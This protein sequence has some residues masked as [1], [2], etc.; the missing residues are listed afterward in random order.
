MQETQNKIEACASLIQEHRQME[1]LLEKLKK[2]LNALNAKD[3]P[4]SILTVMREIEPEMNTHFACEEQVLFPA[5][6][7]YHPMVLMEVEHEELIA[8]RQELLT[9][10]TDGG[11]I[12]LNI[13]QL[14]EIGNR[15]I[16][17]MLDH[18]GR[19]DTGIFPAC[20]RALS[21]EE[22]EA[23]IVGMEKIRQQARQTPTPSIT[24]PDRTFKVHQLDVSSEPQR[25]I[26]SKRIF[27]DAS[28]EAKQITIQAGKSL[29]AHWTPK[30][31]MLICLRGE[32]TF[33]ANNEE[34]N[35]VPGT[36]ITM[37][38]QLQH[39]ISAKT[40][41]DFLLLFRDTALLSP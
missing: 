26:M 14:Q 32:G 21:N 10:L 37:S 22:K 18:I 25:E 30:W 23:V 35:F 36:I 41:C 29:A 28:L 11:Q 8:L 38:P 27:E 20:E 3:E 34:Q 33:T 1:N 2:V 7:P 6:T 15:F 39:S 9:L 17:D 31:A 4:D 16:S 40:I 5:V 19:E 24:R 12:S 13:R